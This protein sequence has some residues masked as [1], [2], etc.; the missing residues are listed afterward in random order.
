MRLSRR[1]PV[2]SLVT[3]VILATTACGGGATGP[4]TFDGTGTQTMMPPDTTQ[5]GISDA[6]V[7][8]LAQGDATWSYYKFAPDDTLVA[9]PTSPHQGRVRTRYNV[10]AATQ[11]DALG[12]VRSPAD[13]PDSS[14]IAKEVYDGGRLVALA[15]MLKLEGDPNAGHGDWLWGEY[16]PDGVVTHS[17]A[18]DSGSC[19]NCHVRGIDHTRMNDSH[20]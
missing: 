19:H 1:R 6:G 20:P 11:L 7:F 16:T 10:Q 2:P 4:A 8:A 18:E 12:K 17:I 3:A 15:V 13:F 9:D 5:S 14:V